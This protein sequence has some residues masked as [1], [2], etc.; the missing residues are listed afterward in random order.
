[1]RWNHR[2]SCLKRQVKVYAKAQE[3]ILSMKFPSFRSPDLRRRKVLHNIRLAWHI[4]WGK[5]NSVNNKSGMT[6]GIEV[7]YNPLNCMT[8]CGSGRS[9]STILWLFIMRYFS[10]Y[11]FIASLYRLH[12]FVQRV[13]QYASWTWGG[14]G[15]GWVESGMW[16]EYWNN[17]RSSKSHKVFSIPLKLLCL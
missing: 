10:G 11:T 7:V 14:K 1:M 4:A 5:M 3:S 9:T 17:L 2:Q 6:R 12:I 15:K 16:P 8:G 13:L